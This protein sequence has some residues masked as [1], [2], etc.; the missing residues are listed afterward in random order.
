MVKYPPSC[1]KPQKSEENAAAYFYRGWLK[2]AVNYSGKDQLKYTL[3]NISYYFKADIEDFLQQVIKRGLTEEMEFI[4]NGKMRT[5]FSERNK[6]SACAWAVRNCRIDLCEGWLNELNDKKFEYI[7]EK[8]YKQK[9]T[10]VENKRDRFEIIT[11]IMY[12]LTYVS[13]DK[14]DELRTKALEKSEFR[15]DRSDNIV[16]GNLLVY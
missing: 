15:N 10:E 2:E 8:W 1:Q 4:L 11:D 9:Y 7:S 16:A 14:L 13:K 6:I 3:E 12:I 5:A